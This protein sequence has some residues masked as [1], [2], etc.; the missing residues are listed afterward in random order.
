MQKLPDWVLKYKTKGIYVKK[1]KTGY[2]LYKGHSER[3]AGKSYPVFRCDEYLGIATEKDGLVPSKPPVKPGIK[4]FRYGFCYISET[5]C[6][7]LRLN[8]K[9]L[10]MNAEVLFVKA[11]LG[12]EGKENQLGYESS[13]LSILFPGLDL[14]ESLSEQEKQFLPTLRRQVASKLNDNL[15]SEKDEMLALSSNLYAVYVNGGWHLSELSER[16]K[17]L[18]LKH[19]ISLELGGKP[20]GV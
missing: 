3:V 1:T 2:A 4:V 15:G 12:Y 5:L 20:Y 7:V 8:P 13:Y 19:S 11:V 18:A 6:N 10:G 9:R 14:D 17:N 16:L